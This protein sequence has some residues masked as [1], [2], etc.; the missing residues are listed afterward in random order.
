MSSR[1]K[2]AF[3][4]AEHNPE[5]ALAVVGG[6]S[7]LER[8]LRE[9]ERA[10]FTK[11]LVTL[12]APISTHSFDIQIERVPA[13][14]IAPNDSVVIACDEICGIRIDTPQSQRQAEDRLLQNL[15]KS[16]QGPVDALINRHISLRITR[17]LCRTGVKPNTVTVFA[18]SIGLVAVGLLTISTSW[19]IR[20][21]GFLIFFQS[22]FD[23]CDGELARLK[24]QTSRTGQWLDNIA[25]DITDSLLPVAL[26][27]AVGGTLW[28][29]LGWIAGGSR[30]LSQ[31]L[32]YR[33]VRKIGGDFHDFRW[34]FET[35]VQTMDQVYD[36]FSPMTWLRA[37]GRRDVYLFLW[38][39]FC[40]I[41]IPILAA[42][43][44]VGLSSV[45]LLFTLIHIVVERQ[46]VSQST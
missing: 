19:A 10:G 7:I 44:G 6:I 39:V 43:Y 37:L 8:K 1:K 16:F 14:Q 17:W 31:L 30:L 5:A 27:F 12:D 3:L 32:Q 42:G 33:I 38:A 21:A 29:S 35:E 26:G 36:R 20:T 40:A 28:I 2:T 34:W 18:M 13:N 45:Y 23:S 9:A 25:D 15:P 11:A 22:I 41:E 24:C 4:V 46:R